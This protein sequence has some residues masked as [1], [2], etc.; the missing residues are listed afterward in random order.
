MILFSFVFNII[1]KR[2]FGTN[3]IKTKL[4]YLEMFGTWLILTYIMFNVRINV[5]EYSKKEMTKYVKSNGETEDYDY[6]YYEIDELGKFALVLIIGFFIIFIGSQQH[7]FKEK[8]GLL[9]EDIA[10]IAESLR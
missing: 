4:Y 6:I 9:N 5:N 3:P 2:L 1:T 8:L 10:I 7:T